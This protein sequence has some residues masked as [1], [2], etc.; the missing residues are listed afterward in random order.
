MK[1]WT[2]V[3]AVIAVIGWCLPLEAAD[4]NG[5]GRDDIGIFRSSSGLWSVR[6]ITRIYFGGAGDL[7]VP[8][9]YNNNGRD[10]IAIFRP[11]TGLWAVREVTRIYYGGGTD[12]PFG[13][14]GGRWTSKG[15][16]LYFTGGNVGI[17]TDSF[18]PQDLL[19]VANGRGYGRRPAPRSA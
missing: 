19:T 11:T 2:M 1:K 14:T 15:N 7:P 8:G 9:D 12:L 10:D 5:D 6:G 18:D 17:G 13:A 4:F 16:D 3:L